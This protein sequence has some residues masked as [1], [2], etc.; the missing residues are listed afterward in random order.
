MMQTHIYI[1]NDNSHDATYV[2]HNA[3][4]M[5]PMYHKQR[6]DWGMEP[7]DWITFLSDGG[8]AHYKCARSFYNLSQ[9]VVGGKPDDYTQPPDAQGKRPKADLTKNENTEWENTL[10]AFIIDYI[11]LGPNHG[12]LLPALLSALLSPTPPPAPRPPP[13]PPPRY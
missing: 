5:L 7:L 10:G 12:L 4:E 1:S 6:H 2:K 8:P 3:D 11:F 13:P 9:L